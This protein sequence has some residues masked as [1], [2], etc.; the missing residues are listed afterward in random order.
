MP[1]DKG[2]PHLCGLKGREKLHALFLLIARTGTLSFATAAS[3]AGPTVSR[4]FRPHRVV[5]L[6][7]RASACGLSPGLRSR[8]VGPA[9][10]GT[11]YS[12][13]IATSP[14]GPER[15]KSTNRGTPTYLELA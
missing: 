8:P 6:S 14:P 5:N 2:H 10:Q 4:P 13:R 11:L 12:V 9:T 15:S 7:P 1:R 3:N